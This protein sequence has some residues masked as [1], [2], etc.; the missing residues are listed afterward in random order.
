M[1][2]PRSWPRAPKWSRFSGRLF[3]STARAVPQPESRP[4]S[5]PI[6]A[7]IVPRQDQTTIL[8]M[9]GP[10]EALKARLCR[11]FNIHP[12]AMSTLLQGI[13]LW[14]Q[15]PLRVVLSAD[16][17]SISNTLGLTDG[18]GFGED[19]LFYNVEVVTRPALRKQVRRIGGL[20]DF[21]EAHQ[22]LRRAAPR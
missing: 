7:M 2:V 12:N 8:I 10:H 17:C 6:I 15:Q 16:S 5:Q 21:R 3:R 14:Y 19:T 11:P 9:D 20:G 18:F 13:S 4:M 22:T 1:R